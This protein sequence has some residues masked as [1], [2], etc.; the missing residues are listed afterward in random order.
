[1]RRGVDN[2]FANLSRGHADMK[3]IPNTKRESSLY[4]A[5]EY[6]ARATKKGAEH[7]FR[8]FIYKDGEFLVA[9]DTHRMH[10]ALLQNIERH[11]GAGELLEDGAYSVVSKTR[12]EIVI[13]Q[14]H[15]AP[16]FPENWKRILGLKEFRIIQTRTLGKKHGGMSQAFCDTMR[17]CPEQMHFQLD[18]LSDIFQSDAME[19]WVVIMGKRTEPCL[20]KNSYKAAVVMPYIE[21]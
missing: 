16:A 12:K 20:F 14:A 7:N 17:G 1:M 13:A 8:G 6:V 4:N 19:S 15:N 5:I 21:C 18:Y 11:E 3:R 2:L 10:I 9:S